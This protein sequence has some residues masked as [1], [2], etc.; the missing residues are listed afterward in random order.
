MR[1][2]H[3]KDSASDLNVIARAQRLIDSLRPDVR[4]GMRSIRGR[5]RH[6]N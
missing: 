4:C 2:R 6:E 5:I 3:G 1:D